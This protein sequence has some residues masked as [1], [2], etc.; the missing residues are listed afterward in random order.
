VD[1]RIHQ[2]L[3]L[4]N[5]LADR[6]REQVFE[7][8]REK[9]LKAAATAHDSEFARYIASLRAAAEVIG[10][11]DFTADEYRVAQRKAVA[12][13]DERVIEASKVIRFFGRWRIAKE[14]LVASDE[15]SP[16]QIEARFRTKMTGV[17]RRFR[18]HDFE[19]ALAG[20]SETL[21]RPPLVSE[22]ELWRRKEIELARE[23][24]EVAYIPQWTAYLRR[25]GRWEHVLVEFG[26]QPEQVE[27]RRE[28]PPVVKVDRYTDAT[29]EMTLRQCA[30]DLGRVPLARDFQRW[31]QREIRKRQRRKIT[32]TVALPSDSPYRTRYGSWNKALLHFGFRQE[33]IDEQFAQVQAT[34]RK[35]LRPHQ[36]RSRGNP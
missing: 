22:Y 36:I 18:R 8:I 35:N 25:W 14:A 34:A 7:L 29:L 17:F 26:Y 1:A 31:R 5:A 9:R 21:G 10:R 12:A 19:R 32:G 23:R 6:E 30:R 11:N 28:H 15:L 20:C 33:E 16:R 4:Y 3:A 24:G 13:G 27:L 2:V